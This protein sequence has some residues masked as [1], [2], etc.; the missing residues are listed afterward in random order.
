MTPGLWR[1]MLDWLRNKPEIE[2]LERSLEQID[3]DC[4][5]VVRL[6]R[7]ANGRADDHD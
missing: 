5:E 7:R 1:R 6:A 2:V 3:R 4:A